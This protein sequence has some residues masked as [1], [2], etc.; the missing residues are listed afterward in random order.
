MTIK[1]LT[2]IK[3]RKPDT[4]NLND[5]LQWLGTS[6]GLFGNR[7]RDKSCY[8]LFLE[9]LKAAK[10]EQP[11]SSDEL[12]NKIGLS[13]GTVIHHIVKLRQ[14]GI[15]TI[16]G[17]KYLLRENNLTILIDDLKRDTEKAYVEMQEA[18]KEIDEMLG[19]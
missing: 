16:E 9:L 13:R 4:P 7:D 18:A 17:K 14:S 11:L 3:I 12:A 10:K 8:R 15:L 2:I 1:R 19:L 5:E 6:L